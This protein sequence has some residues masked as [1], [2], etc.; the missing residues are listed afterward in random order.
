MKMQR[1]MIPTMSTNSPFPY[2]M[3]MNRQLNLYVSVDDV[4]EN[5]APYFQSDGN[6][7]VLENETFVFEFANVIRSAPR[8]SPMP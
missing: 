2:P 7:S 3:A 1:I 6:L 4:F 5:Q 8:Y